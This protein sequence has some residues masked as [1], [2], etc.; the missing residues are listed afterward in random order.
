MNCCG[1]MQDYLDKLRYARA[2]LARAEA[3]LPHNFLPKSK[4]YVHVST[5][6]AQVLNRYG[7]SARYGHR[8]ME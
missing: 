1:S 5:A 2:A 7:G 6:I 8:I 4:Y 3:V